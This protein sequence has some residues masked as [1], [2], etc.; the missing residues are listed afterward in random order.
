MNTK[1]ILIVSG[2]R[3]GDLHA[4]KLMKELNNLRQNLNFIGIGG[5]NMKKSGLSILTELDDISIVGFS[6]ILAKGLKL[7]SLY[8][9]FEEIF[10]EKNISLVILVDFPGFNLRLA[11]LAKKYNIPVCYFIAPQI[12]AWGKHRIFKIKK[13][14][15]LLI[16][17]FPFEKKIFEESG[18]NVEYYGHPLF[19]EPIFYSNYGHR[20][21][22]DKLLAILPGSR[23]QEISSHINLIADVIKLFSDKYPNFKIGIAIQNDLKDK[24]SLTKLNKLNKSIEFWDNSYELMKK[25]MIG[26]IKTG[27]S[28]LE[29]AL[30]GLP[31]VMF[32]KTT[33]LSY[34]LGKFLINIKYLSIV[35]VLINDRVIPEYIQKDAT[36]KNIVAGLQTLIE[37]ETLTSKM[38]EAFIKLR[39]MLDGPGCSRNSAEKIV[40]FFG[41]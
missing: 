40:S 38:Q 17:A 25:S 29:A 28:N 8:Q 30:L 19:D 15:D 35:N 23:K 24:K 26:L 33:F 37:N 13:Y 4:G 11:A 39:E 22:R 27:T 7:H 21:G 31:F 3:S 36:P 41:L 5:S 32:Y 10:K 18:I 6:Q 1:N 16:V 34:L 14:V 12:W 20:R 2:E 9:R